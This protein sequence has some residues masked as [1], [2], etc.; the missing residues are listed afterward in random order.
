MLGHLTA[1]G[2]RG[3]GGSGCPALADCLELLSPEGADRPGLRVRAGF[4]EPVVAAA[5]QRVD[6]FAKGVRGRVA[7][8]SLFFWREDAIEAG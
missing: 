3:E 2:L 7:A 4:P 1:W 5:Q 8:G 6:A